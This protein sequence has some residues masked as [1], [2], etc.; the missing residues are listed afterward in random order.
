MLIACLLAGNGETILESKALLPTP[1]N[2]APD[3]ATTTEAS[4]TSD[5]AKKPIKKRKIEDSPPWKSATTETP[6]AFIIDG[7]RKS[8]RTNPIPFEFL[9]ASNGT[10]TRG[11]KRQPLNDVSKALPD[12][13]SK[14]RQNG[15]GKARLQ[16]PI[17]VSNR[18]SKNTSPK[19]F[20]G[21]AAATR[22]PSVKRSA[23]AAS[24][25]TKTSPYN[26]LRPSPAI[27]TRKSAR[28][29]KKAV[30]AA[31]EELAAG[32]KKRPAG[33]VANG[34]SDG[35]SSFDSDGDLEMSPNF[36]TP[37]VKVKLKFGLPKPVITHPSQIPPPKPFA[38]F[39]EFMLQDEPDVEATQQLEEAAREEAELRNKIDHE[40]RHGLLTQEN[41]SIFIPEQQVEPEQQYSHQDHLVAH[42]IHFR[43]LMI[44]ERKEH[45]DLMRK[46]MAALMTEVK[47]RTPRTREEIEQEEY[48]E[49]RKLYKEQMAQLRRKWDEVTKASHPSTV[50]S[51]RDALTGTSGS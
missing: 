5:S 7:R 28:A 8:G 47:R 41:C 35:G 10:P 21:S 17:R 11:R 40:A 24:T 1:S 22:S 12:S 18:Y 27:G 49:N 42:A 6:T 37:K 2:D 45:V 43:K 25:P 13:S 39:D 32:S 15:N 23:P 34:F 51:Y 9:A 14:G 19:S 31:E 36:K 38:S 16:S 44:K 33:G 30:A 3:A 20:M 46:R 26:K 29:L 4:A 50:F 48:I